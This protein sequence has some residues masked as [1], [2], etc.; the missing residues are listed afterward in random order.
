MSAS[1]ITGMMPDEIE[2]EDTG[3]GTP[4]S[5]CVAQTAAVYAV[6]EKI[7]RQIAKG[8]PAPD[9][10]QLHCIPHSELQEWY[11]ELLH[12]ANGLDLFVP[13]LDLF[14]QAEA[15]GRRPS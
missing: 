11:A 8:L 14:G 5:N 4:S 7:A 12:A 13:M 1:V 2:T 3:D 6:A 15:T 10:E 9:R